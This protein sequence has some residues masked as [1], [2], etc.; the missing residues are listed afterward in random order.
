MV[1]AL[2]MQAGSKGWGMALCM[3]I[4]GCS[5]LQPFPV[6]RGRLE[7]GGRVAT[8]QWGYTESSGPPRSCSLLETQGHGVGLGA[9]QDQAQLR[10]FAGWDWH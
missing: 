10:G 4:S 1:L 8:V 2:W 7:D 5:V 3:S 6:T 9:R